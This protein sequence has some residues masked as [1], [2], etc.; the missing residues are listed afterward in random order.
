MGAGMKEVYGDFC[1]SHS[2]SVEHYKLQL[3]SNKKLQT[4]T[5]VGQTKKIIVCYFKDTYGTCGNLVY[6]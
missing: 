6:F 4:F 1:A 2:K 3:K 5:K